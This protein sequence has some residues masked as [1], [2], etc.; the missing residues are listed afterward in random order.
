MRPL[1][2]GGVSDLD[3][4][5]RRS[6]RLERLL[7][8]G[9]AAEGRG[10]HGLVDGV[11]RKLPPDLARKLRLVATV[12]N[13][14]VHDLDYTAIDDRRGF[15]RACDEAERELSRLAGPGVRDSFRL[16]GLV[17]AALAVLLI[18]GMGIA[19]WMLRSRGVPLELR[20]W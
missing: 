9:F 6:K 5:V 18:A 14:I 12:R 13:K 8:D 1:R 2:S 17:V 7:R 15:V 20:L 4:A 3:L 11:E 16:V 19:V 10:L